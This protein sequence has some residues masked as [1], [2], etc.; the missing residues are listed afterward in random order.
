VST[1]ANILLAGNFAEYYIV[2]R[3]GMSVIYDP[4]VKSTGNGRPTGQGGWYSFWRVGADVVDPSAFRLL[5]LNTVAAAT[6]L[7]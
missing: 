4:M 3:V 2:D 7:A 1:G 5:Q 6:A